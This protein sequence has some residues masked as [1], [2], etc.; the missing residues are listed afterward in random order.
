MKFSTS[1]SFTGL[2]QDHD[3]SLQDFM[4]TSEKVCVVVYQGYTASFEEGHVGLEIT[5]SSGAILVSEI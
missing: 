1:Q 4:F 3:M 2:A 5:F